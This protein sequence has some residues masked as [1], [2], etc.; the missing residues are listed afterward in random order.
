MAEQASAVTARRKLRFD[1]RRQLVVDV[2]A[3]PVM[4]GPGRLRGVEIEAGADAEI[5]GFRIAGQIQA[6]RAGVAGHQHQAQF[7]CKALRT[8]LDDEGFFGAGQASEEV[9]RRNRRLCRLRR[10]EHGKAHLGAGAAG[11]V[12]VVAELATMTKRHTAGLHAARLVRSVGPLTVSTPQ[13][14]DKQKKPPSQGIGN[15]GWEE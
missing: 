9:Q 6:A 7:G 3:H 14:S 8:G 2:L 12:A 11:G 15:G 4:H 5:P 13:R 10:H 1:Q